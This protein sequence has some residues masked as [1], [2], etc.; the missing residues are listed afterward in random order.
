MTPL[1]VVCNDLQRLSL[2]AVDQR[3]AG[4]PPAEGC[5]EIR[6]PSV[7]SV[8]AYNRIRIR[9]TL[10]ARAAIRPRWKDVA[11]LEWGHS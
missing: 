11:R 4:E 1:G 3:K 8:A 7:T 6:V 10:F 5:N 9:Q 2:G